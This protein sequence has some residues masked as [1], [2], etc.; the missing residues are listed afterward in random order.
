MTAKEFV[1]SKY[2]NARSER[3]V[4]GYNKSYYLIRLG[5]EYIYF[6]SGDTESKAWVA[7]KK[8][9]MEL[10]VNLNTAKYS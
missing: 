4:T 7:A 9:I 10:E 5:R 1:K 3:Q 8:K 6:S 2:P